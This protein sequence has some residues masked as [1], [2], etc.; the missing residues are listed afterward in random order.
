MNP[1]ARAIPIVV[2]QHAEDSA[3]LCNSR[4]VMVV[5]AH[6]KLHH[7][8]RLDD[9]LSAHL[10]GLAVAGEFGWALCR[11]A[12]ATPGVGE[13]FAATVWAIEEQDAQRLGRILAL[14]EALPEARPGVLLAF[15][16]VS[17][18]WLRGLIRDM[19]VSPSPFRRMVGVAAC[20]FHLVDPGPALEAALADADAALRAQALR[21]AG[22]CG[23]RDLL[24]ACVGALE[25][26]DADCRFW[27]ARSA[28]LLGD[29]NASLHT[30]QGMTLAPGVHRARAVALVLKLVTPA[31][32]ASILKAL[33]EVPDGVRTLIKGVGVAGDPHFVPWLT[34]QMEG[35]ELARLAGESFCMITGLDLAWLDLERKPP[36]GV[37]LGPTDD[38]EDDDI[39]MD[40]DEGLSW[41][42]P[43]KVQAWW[44]AN[45]QDFHP[46]M[47]Y[48]M[49]APL[50]WEHCLRVRKDG[51]Q[52]QR[53]AAAEYL[54]LLQP[55]TP[56]FPTS[57][58]AWRQQRWLETMNA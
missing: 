30:L 12:L 56:L 24:G 11:A 21:T 20:D 14:A 47:R 46:G 28:A 41:P 23:R 16:W 19:L 36:E 3:M 58:P 54:C 49:G 40:E 13:V 44:S 17:A 45:S 25:D 27:A 1:A 53:I 48:F 38:P 9:R 50:S 34:G 55:G 6:C 51:Y 15:N 22:D 37:D 8:R 10:D 7:L 31:H 33:F 2:Q 42:D 29:R 32:A 18:Q 43:S 4:L 39:T 52:R 57:A 26:E 5:A 35:V